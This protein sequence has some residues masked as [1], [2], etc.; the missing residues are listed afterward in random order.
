MKKIVALSIMLFT[1]ALLA[2]SPGWTTLKE[3]NIT[4]GSNAYD[5]FTNGTGNHIIVQA[6]DENPKKLKYYRMKVDGTYDIGP[7]NIETSEVISPSISGDATRIYIVYRKSTDNNLIRTKYSTNGGMSWSDVNLNTPEGNASSIECV[8]SKGNL[9]VTFLVGTT[10]Y[11]NYYNTTTPPPSWLTQSISVSET[12]SASNPRICV[13]NAGSNNLV[14]FTF[15]TDNIRLKWRRYTVGG[16]L[17]DLYSNVTSFSGAIPNLGF[18]VDDQYLYQFFKQI[19]TSVLEWTIRRVTDNYHPTGGG[20]SNNNTSVQKIF[21][22]TTANNKTYTA[23]W[24]QTNDPPPTY[25]ISRIGFNGTYDLEED[26][27]YQNPNLTPVNIVNLSA[28]GNDVHVVWKDNL[29]NNKL[30]YKYYDDVPVPP[31]NLTVTKSANNHPLL[32]WTNPNPD[33]EYFV[34]YKSTG[35]W[36]PIDQP[37]STTY[38]DLSE[39]YCTAIPPAQCESGHW[40]SYYVKAM[41]FGDH[42]SIASNT[43]ETLVL[44]LYPDKISANHNS[45]QVIEYSLSQNFPNPFNPTTTINYSI[46]SAGDV[47]LKVYDILGTEVASLVNEVKEAG[48]YSVTFNA[49]NLPSGMYVYILSTGNFIDTKKLILLK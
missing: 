30:R 39:S 37:T 38:E 17:S 21:S 23:A 48:N 34:V 20:N 27:I 42:L 43:V 2:Q 32:S 33:I 10:V 9:H 36:Q 14:Y 11:F 13:W 45:N 12:F 44:G 8:F 46:K 41:D 26:L 7:T 15:I 4:V 18:A 22:T 35:G 29:S 28:A 31:Q 1:A 3:T 24:D 49:A 6:N 25:R 19:S 47:S 40:V 5:I 16:G